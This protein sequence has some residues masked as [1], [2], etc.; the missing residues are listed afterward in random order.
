[1]SE[2]R[3]GDEVD[4]F[5]AWIAQRMGLHFDADKREFLADV[6]RERMQKTGCMH[7]G[8]YLKR[9]ENHLVGTAE[10]RELAPSLTVAETY[11][12]RHLDHFRA[13][14][15]VVLPNVLKRSGGVRRLRILSAG[16]AS[17]EE[18]Y[19]LAMLLER[20]LLDR[21]EWRIEILG[22]DI[23]PAVLAKARLGA[24]SAWALRETGADVRARY[25]RQK[26]SEFVLSDAIREM[27]AFEERNLAEE[28]FGFWKAETFDVIF[29][30]NVT[31]YL[32]PECTRAAVARMERALIPGGY[33]FMGYAETLRG[34][35]N[36]FHLCHSDHAFYYR[37]R[38]AGEAPI[39]GPIQEA[40][41]PADDSATWVLQEDASWVDAIQRSSD[42]IA[43]LAGPGGTQPPGM[44]PA[45]GVAAAARWSLG[46][47]LELL[48]QERFS[49]ALECLDALPQEAQ[50]DADAKLLLAV[51]LV[52]AGRME[53][54]ESVCGQL[55]KADELNAGAHYLM[56][57]CRERTGDLSA[58]AHHDRTAAYLD[59]GFAMPHFH[60]GMLARR[61]GALGEARRALESALEL[62]AREDA[63]RI[64][65]F[66]GG[67]SREALVTLCRTQLQ[68]LGGGR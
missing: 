39:P 36:A 52:N 42:R 26:G 15:E 16:C 8:E 59:A 68:A 37:S 47:A 66:G 58:S 24:Y 1:M 28:D 23:N 46:E 44:K 43:V 22:I 19:S 50:A 27:V 2:A 63:S 57:L 64:L 20:C 17:G 55:L 48:R 9:L 67:F 21:A 41:I 5:G 11:F 3:S 56:A 25:F 40:T 29:C 51:L 7:A 4:A 54:A 34:I 18:A 12:F 65:L 31:M 53:K 14:E 32:K 35:S 10:A 61:T 30:R 62:F 38:E 33:L 6:L 45:P 60:L 49:A 13:F